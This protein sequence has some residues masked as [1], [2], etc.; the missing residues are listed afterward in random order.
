MFLSI[1]IPTLTSR[2]KQFKKLHNELVKQ[3]TESGFKNDVEILI[4]ED[5]K[6]YP[7]GLKRNLLI[8]AAIGDFIVFIDDDDKIDT[9]YVSLI[10]NTIK[11]NPDI[12]C[13]GIKGLLI[14]KYLGNREFIHSLQ[15]TEYLEDEKYYYRPPNHLNPIKKE[16][17]KNYKF[18]IINFGEDFAWS[19]K[20]CNDKILK[21]EKF[22]NKI[23]YYYYYDSNKS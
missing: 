17:I 1:L 21:K 14:N 13:I 5:N 12:D 8:E 22:I 11:N 7:I 15:Y 9:E 6:M 16:L 2:K 19:M 20:I 4:F 18:P 23:L 10:C 3:I